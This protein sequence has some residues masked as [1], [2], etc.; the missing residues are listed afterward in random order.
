MNKPTLILSID[1]LGLGSIDKGQNSNTWKTILDNSQNDELVFFKEVIQESSKLF[2]DYPGADSYLGHLTMSGVDV[3]KASIKPLAYYKKSILQ[4]LQNKGIHA[5]V[6]K[7]VIVVG[8]K[9][10]IYDNFEADLGLAINMAGNLEKIDFVQMKLI[11]QD[12]RKII[13]NSRLIVFAAKNVSVK[14]MLKFYVSSGEY[15]GL[16]TPLTGI[17]NNSFIAKHF[18]YTK[19]IT[20]SIQNTALDH[21]WQIILYGKFANII[22]VKHKNLSL[23]DSID[24]QQIFNNVNKMQNKQ[25][26]MHFV[27]IQQTDLAGHEGNIQKYIDIL[28]IINKNLKELVVNQ[29][30]NILLTSDHGNDPAVKDGKHSREFVPFWIFGFK[31]L[32]FKKKYVRQLSDVSAFLQ[33]YVLSK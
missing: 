22:S 16:K 14:N 1:G 24:P 11:A 2:L 8:D 33:D 26:F 31:E 6:F 29:K 9:F 10:I 23:F 18:P 7:G 32:K 25:K 13:K 17:Y 20:N 12:V 19:Q 28:K 5:R 21:G 3:Q 15:K 4:L 27:N 30:F